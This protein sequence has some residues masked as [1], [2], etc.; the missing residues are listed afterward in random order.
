M[1]DRAVRQTPLVA[2]LCLAL[3]GCGGAP[4]PDDG[5]LR[6]AVSV[7][8]QA[9]L[10]E[11]IAGPDARIQ[12]VAPP[13]SSP[14]T[15]Q[16]TDADAARIARS[17]LY[18]RIGVPSERGPWLA[19]LG[20][21]RGPLI[22]DQ[23]AGLELRPI[24]GHDHGQAHHDHDH[25]H[26]GPDPHVWL[27]PSL[28]VRQARTVAEA[29]AAVDPARAAEY[30]ARADATVAELEAL[31]AEL[32]ELLAP[33]RGRAFL[34]YHPAWGYLADAYGLEQIAVER[35]GRDPS[36]AELTALARLVRERGIGSLFVQPQI[37]ARS[38]ARIAEALDLELV[39]IDPLR[40]DVP[41]NLRSVAA[42][43]VDSWR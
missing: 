39:T 19:A 6:I 26:H 14:E 20:G 23:H 37:D 38:A 24:E 36:D 12:V 32:E 16:P 31:D 29:L 4:P 43:L 41:D 22:V 1:T 8:P 28:L 34:V 17:D 42:A 13:G 5:E 2:A 33:Y 27:A 11:R 10:V 25:D 7:A 18:L 40:R 35:A 9:W 21:D 15:H 30:A 3:F